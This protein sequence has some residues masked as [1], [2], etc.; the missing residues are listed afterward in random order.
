MIDLLT[1]PRDHAVRARR[2]RCL[3]VT[4]GVGLDRL[5]PADFDLDHHRTLFAALA[6][7][8][9]RAWPPRTS[10]PCPVA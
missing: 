8:G 3:L 9:H 5:T 7:C 4:E 10:W 6:R 1:I 2:A